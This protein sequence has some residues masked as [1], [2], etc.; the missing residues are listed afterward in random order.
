MNSIQIILLVCIVILL[1]TAA[2]VSLII[3][4]REQMGK[5]GVM[6]DE[7]VPEPVSNNN[8]HIYSVEEYSEEW[9]IK[10]QEIKNT[11]ASVFKEKALSIDHVGNT[12]VPGMKS[13]PSI[14][15][16]VVVQRIESFMTEKRLMQ[17]LGYEWGGKYVV[18]GT[19]VF[20]K[21]NHNENTESGI[22]ENI[23][24]CE[25]G[26]PQA[27]QFVNTRDSLIASAINI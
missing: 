1:L 15:V 12:A 25:A 4:M 24:I 2:I 21:V 23:H 13:T 17:A 7:I 14:D 18:P 8:E 20:H 19:I 9:P 11:L 5:E 16:L 22:V 6:A 3:R 27:L 10:F 26:S